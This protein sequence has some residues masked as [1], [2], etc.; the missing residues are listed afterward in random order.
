[1]PEP[2]LEE[3]VVED[4]RTKCFFDISHGD[5]LRARGASAGI[6]A[7]APVPLARAMHTRQCAIVHGAGPA[8][9]A[10]RSPRC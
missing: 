7:C 10:G 4:V 8:G 1:M 3:K 9:A 5:L 6:R 2:D